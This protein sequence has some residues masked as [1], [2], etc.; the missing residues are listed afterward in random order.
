MFSAFLQ[1]WGVFKDL[2]YTYNHSIFRTPS[3]ATHWMAQ[4][5][6]SR[7]KFDRVLGVL[8]S[9]SFPSAAFSAKG[10]Q[11]IKF[12]QTPPPP[13]PPNKNASCAQ[14]AANHW[15]PIADLL[16][17]IWRTARAPDEQALLR[18]LS[19][20]E[21]RKETM[22]LGSRFLHIHFSSPTK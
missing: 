3:I 16:T 12:S 2:L 10:N 9:I 14:Q 18:L 5:G 15:T 22:P 7:T 6:K 4:G 13:L 20:I 1:A 8:S 21:E 11:D 17:Q 19:P